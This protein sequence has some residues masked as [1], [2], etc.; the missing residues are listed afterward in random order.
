MSSD[1][2]EILDKAK[3]R[4]FICSCGKAYLSYAALFT[5]IKLKHNGKVYI[6]SIKAPG[7]ISKPK[8]SQA[9]RG[10]PSNVVV[11]ELNEL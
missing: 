11:K 9:K 2:C 8:P 4:N 1:E 5:H 7:P 6:H 3:S 10:R